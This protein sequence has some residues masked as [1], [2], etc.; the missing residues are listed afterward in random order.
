MCDY[1][2]HIIILIIL[3]LSSF[4]LGS[5]A[6]YCYKIHF[7][8]WEKIWF[9]L[10]IGFAII[11]YGTYFLGLVGLL[12]PRILWI[13]V[14]IPALFSFR[15]ISKF[16]NLPTVSFLHWSISEKIAG[17]LLIFNIIIFGLAAGAPPIAYDSVMYHLALPKL[18]LQEGRITFYPFINCSLWPALLE[19][20]YLLP[21]SFGALET[22]QLIHWFMGVLCLGW[23]FQVG[24]MYYNR[25]V[26]L[27]AAN[28]LVNT[29]LFKVLSV[30][31]LIDLGFCFFA[32]LALYAFIQYREKKCAFWLFLSGIEAGLACGVKLTGI[33]WF[34]SLLLLLFLQL[35]KKY[36]IKKL[37]YELF[38]VIILFM[39]IMS[40]WF[41]RSYWHTGNPVWPFCYKLFNGPYWDVAQTKIW[42]SYG[43]AFM[44]DVTLIGTISNK[45]KALFS[46]S[47][48]YYFRFGFLFILFT[49]MSI[50]RKQQVF[51][52]K[53]RTFFYIIIIYLV[54]YVLFFP[55]SVRYLIPIIP[56]MALAI[57]GGLYSLMKKNR[58]ANLFGYLLLIVLIS[59]EF[60][61]FD[62]IIWKKIK[63]T[64]GFMSPHVYLQ[65]NLEIYP[66]SA[67][68]NE[69]FKS[70]QKI[71]L[72]NDT[73]GLYINCDY[74]WGD[75]INQKYIDY[76]NIQSS[77]D[78]VRIWKEKGITTILVKG[79]KIFW[80]VKGGE[81]ISAFFS[82]TSPFIK[83]GD[84][85]LFNL[86]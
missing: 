7:N 16:K 15:R 27:I 66:I 86:E 85:Y 17:L 10:S 55:N 26:G 43:T 22:T 6:L 1:F 50:V 39:I 63:T 23:I 41:I 47:G 32:L 45:I 3:I 5:L 62:K 64:I 61:A 57:A 75:P 14:G 70:G 80:P 82:K 31:A 11:S 76:D 9:S 12:R 37:I 25:W 71:L 77:D 83:K 60:P 42:L 78:L 35:Q 18:Y 53:I 48:K 19:M 51:P 46:L 72:L 4:E 40:P 28:I 21:M 58:Y 29:I 74:V 34:V 20:F 49:M 38:I 2:F 56:L 52:N 36:N 84:Y 13:L 79:T 54:Q 33:I 69:N 8:R 44:P 67:W 30:T 81:C 73:R 65:K 24:K 68:I 59:F